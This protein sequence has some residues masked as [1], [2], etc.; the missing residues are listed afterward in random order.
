MCTS[1]YI[2]ICWRE[3]LGR[4]QGDCLLCTSSADDLPLNSRSTEKMKGVRSWLF[5]EATCVHIHVS[6]YIYIDIHI[7]T[8]IWVYWQAF[9]FVRSQSLGVVFSATQCVARSGSFKGAF[10]TI[11]S[12][13]ELNRHSHIMKQNKKQLIYIYISPSFS[14]FFS[15][16]QAFQY[17]ELRCENKGG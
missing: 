13:G 3:V 2:Y 14:R 11:I 10:R 9:L 4:G 1:T 6:I 7:Y 15:L 17:F 12:P 8:Y 16:S 5:A